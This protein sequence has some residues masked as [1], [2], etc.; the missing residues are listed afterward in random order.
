MNDL[1]TLY[2]AE[3]GVIIPV[4]KPTKLTNNKEFSDEYAHTPYVDEKIE[5]PQ[6]PEKEDSEKED[7]DEDTKD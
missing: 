3:Q 2:N 5:E 4:K 1:K 7:S 6:Y